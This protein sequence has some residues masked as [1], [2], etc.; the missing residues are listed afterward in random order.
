MSDDARDAT[1][2]L[3]VASV[4]FAGT[5]MTVIRSCKSAIACAVVLALGV[6]N[7]VRVA[8]YY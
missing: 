5:A 1:A 8:Q 7:L 3:A 2:V 6:L 4:V